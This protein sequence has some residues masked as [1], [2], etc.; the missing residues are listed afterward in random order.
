MATYLWT[1]SLLQGSRPVVVV[2][3]HGPT[4]TRGSKWIATYQPGTRP[5]ATYRASAPFHDG[6]IA[7]FNALRFKNMEMMATWTVGSIGSSHSDD[8]YYVTIA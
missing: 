3:Y 2:K 4:D 6:P 7:A 1:G 5:G 8:I